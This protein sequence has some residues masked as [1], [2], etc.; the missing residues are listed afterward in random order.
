MSG[1]EA[2]VRRLTVIPASE[3]ISGMAKAAAPAN[4]SLT[5]GTDVGPEPCLFFARLPGGL[6]TTSAKR[7]S[8]ARSGNRHPPADVRRSTCW[9]AC[10]P[11]G[12]PLATPPTVFRGPRR[13]RW[14][15][16]SALPWSW[17]AP[18]M[19]KETRRCRRKRRGRRER[20]ERRTLGRLPGQL[21][22]TEGHGRGAAP[23]ARP[24]AEEMVVLDGDFN[25]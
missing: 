20:G 6:H 8:P 19:L 7:N 5:H 4:R 10:Y 16:W 14:G 22:A 9:A 21:G 1:I 2:R 23:R 15:G 25:A 24:A 12:D 13:E 11:A 17:G 18:G 3:G